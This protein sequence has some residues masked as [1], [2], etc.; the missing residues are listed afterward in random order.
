MGASA[1]WLLVP[2]IIILGLLAL[3]EIGRR[4][5]YRER[6]PLLPW[7]AWLSMAPIFLMAMV[8]GLGEG[9]DN[10]AWAAGGAAASVI[11]KAT[12]SYVRSHTG[13]TEDSG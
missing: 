8:N 6:G 4:Q 7:W 1:L 12:V 2:A 11:I 9:N 10:R 3:A 13:S 5:G